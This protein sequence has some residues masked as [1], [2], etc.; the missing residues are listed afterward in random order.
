MHDAWVADQHISLSHT[1]C[2]HPLRRVEDWVLFSCA[3][4]ETRGEPHLPRPRAIEP[5]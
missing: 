5:S 2:F 1:R 4:R 3:P